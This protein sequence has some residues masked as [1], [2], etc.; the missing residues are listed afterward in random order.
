MNKNQ[1]NWV[2]L[3]V[4]AAVLA[5]PAVEIYRNIQVHQ[6]LAASQQLHKD[7][8]RRLDKVRTDHAAKVAK[9][10]GHS[11]TTIEQK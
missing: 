4:L 1:K 11:G 6:E 10:G 5:W 9:V 3:A 8:L 2:R 7:V